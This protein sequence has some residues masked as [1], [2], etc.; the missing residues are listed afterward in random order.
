MLSVGYGSAYHV[1]A[2]LVAIHGLNSMVK[3]TKT[4]E[5]KLIIYIRQLT[6]DF[7]TSMSIDTNQIDHTHLSK[8]NELNCVTIF[9]SRMYIV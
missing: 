2:I 3:P 8:Q 4:N 9:L 6:H 7:D 5:F 1:F